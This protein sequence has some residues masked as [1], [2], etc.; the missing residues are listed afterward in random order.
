[1]GSVREGKQGRGER[2]I[3][4]GIICGLIRGDFMRP[5]ASLEAKAKGE[6]RTVTV[7]LRKFLNGRVLL[8]FFSGGVTV[9][10]P[11]RALCRVD[12]NHRLVRCEV[13]QGFVMFATEKGRK[14]GE[15][16]WISSGL[17]GTAVGGLVLRGFCWSLYGF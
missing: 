8:G 7:C 2:E 3:L 10:R 17:P 6:K 14:L 11:L 4:G 13:V 9:L 16:G 12:R 5:P 1:M 15:I